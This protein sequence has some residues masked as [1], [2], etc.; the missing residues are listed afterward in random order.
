[1]FIVSILAKLER[2][3][4]PKVNSEQNAICLFSRLQS[5]GFIL[6]FLPLH[7]Y[8]ALLKIDF[9]NPLINLMFKLPA[10]SLNF[11][12][13]PSFLLIFLILFFN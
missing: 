2:D 9:L 13:I 5:I 12:S 4:I 1:M 7:I 11:I 8:S 3:I 6:R 10:N